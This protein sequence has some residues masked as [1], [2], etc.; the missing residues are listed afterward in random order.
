MCKRP[1][2]SRARVCANGW[3]SV[4][5]YLRIYCAC[6]LLSRFCSSSSSSSLLPSIVLH[7][8]LI[9]FAYD[10]RIRYAV[11]SIQCHSKAM[12]NWNGCR[13]G[14]LC[15]RRAL[16]AF[17]RSFFVYEILDDLFI[18]PVNGWHLFFDAMMKIIACTLCAHV[19]R[20]KSITEFV[21]ISHTLCCFHSSMWNNNDAPYTS[22]H[23][24]TQNDDNVCAEWIK[25]KN[26]HSKIHGKI[27]IKTKGKSI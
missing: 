25:M 13:A 6:V 23:I 24:H 16:T 14:C 27:I 15:L 26:S 8:T 20:N 3:N 18:R 10:Y 17:C 11:Y 2:F 19:E 7:L 12:A 1:L 5:S 9:S 21:Q 4:C 22:S